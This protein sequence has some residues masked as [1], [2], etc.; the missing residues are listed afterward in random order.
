MSEQT[1]SWRRKICTALSFAI[2]ADSL[3]FVAYSLVEGITK[4]SVYTGR[5]GVWLIKS[6]LFE[7]LATVICIA[8]ILWMFLK[9]KSRWKWQAKLLLYAWGLTILIS[10]AWNLFAKTR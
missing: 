7:L 4:E 9:H 5:I 2:V 3:I 6:T 8:L 10:W 1:S